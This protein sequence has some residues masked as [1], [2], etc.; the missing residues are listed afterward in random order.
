MPPRTLKSRDL[1]W[2]SH[3]SGATSPDTF[4]VQVRRE[5]STANIDGVPSVSRPCWKQAL[6]RCYLSEPS[7]Q[8]LNIMVQKPKASKP[9]P[10]EPC[11]VRVH[12]ACDLTNRG[13]HQSQL[14]TKTQSWTGEQ[15]LMGGGGGL[16]QDCIWPLSRP[17]ATPVI[18]KFCFP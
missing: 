7:Q 9:R 3:C 16:T 12:R 18:K 1:A 5:A 13:S 2:K 17:P 4:R 8:P 14:N 10:S 11:H 6:D 15:N